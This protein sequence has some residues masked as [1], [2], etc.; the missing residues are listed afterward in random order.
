[1]FSFDLHTLKT[2]PLKT[3]EQLSFGTLWLFNFLRAHK[4]LN[5]VNEHLLD[6]NYLLEACGGAQ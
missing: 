3:S 4:V 2:L 5:D 1:M 6:G